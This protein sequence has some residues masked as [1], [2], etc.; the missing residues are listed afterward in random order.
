MSAIDWLEQ[1][2]PAEL[3][4]GDPAALPAPDGSAPSAE[5]PP[6]AASA[7]SPNVT[8]TELGETGDG[9][10]GLL[11]AAVTGFPPDIWQGS[12]PATITRLLRQ[13]EVEALPA[14]QSLLYTLL[15]A[16][17]LP[18]GAPEDGEALLLT[19]V[20]R[21]MTLGAVEPAEALVERAGPD[22]PDLF[23]RYFDLALLI[24][25]QDTV[26]QDLL[27]APHLISDYAPRI[28]CQALTGDWLVAA[29]TL[30]GA[31]AIGGLEPAEANLLTRFLDPEM[32][33]G[34]P[35]LP[36]PA[37]LTPLDYRLLEAIGES[38][39]TSI[40]PRAFAVIELSG[41]AGWKAQ[42][43]S[44]ERLART[45]AVSENRLIG[46]YTAREPAASGGVWDRV[47]A[48]QSLD[49][50]LA[51][52]N[53]DR[54]ATALPEAWRAMRGARLD[55]PFA[56]LFGSR[57]LEVELSGPAA[58]TAREVGFLSDVYEATATAWGG[59]ASRQGRFLASLAKGMPD[60]ALARTGLE[61]AVTEGFLDTAL[62]DGLRRQLDEGRLGEVI[63]EAMERVS[64]G[65]A[66]DL[67]DL[68]EALATLRTVGLEDMAR[69]TALQLVLMAADA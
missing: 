40:L 2:P 69:R 46:I 53:T 15:L 54:I 57:L 50:A 68:A 7:T 26:C 38:P 30:E 25:E 31:A 43:E 36:P 45:G 11:P 23:Q 13:V 28:Y 1:N 4:P 61:R 10:V 5:E 17:A 35:P 62:P 29:T 34:L 21:L 52:G 18:P 27:R 33:E 44:A 67:R 59:P 8:V 41:D 55:V 20:D 65:A 14:M 63:L 9:A 60:D 42:I 64:A 19:R 32:A 39:P 6:V 22:T 12:S 37:D 49:R 58:E 56:K 66:G 51:A 24:G 3:R 16:E 47:E 48:V